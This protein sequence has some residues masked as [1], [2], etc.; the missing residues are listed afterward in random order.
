ML[1]IICKL[2]CNKHFFD[3]GIN[4]VLHGHKNTMNEII[5]LLNYCCKYDAEVVA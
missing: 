3:M 5:K 1:I 2:I 4:Y